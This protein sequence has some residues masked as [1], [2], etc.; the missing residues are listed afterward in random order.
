M[1][2]SRSA[3]AARCLLALSLSALHAACDSETSGE[4]VQ[5]SWQLD[6]NSAGDNADFTTAT[7]YDVHLEQAVIALGA[8]YA[9][10]PTSTSQSAVAQ[11]FRFSSVA[12]AHGGLDA[13][14]GRSV[15]AE[16]PS[17]VAPI[18]IDALSPEVIP[19]PSVMAEAGS[20][21]AV[22]LELAEAGS[23]DAAPLQ[24]A[25][26]FVRGRATNAEHSLHFSATVSEA[27]P[28]NIDLTG[29]QQSL[30]PRSVLHIQVHPSAWFEHCDF[31]QLQPATSEELTVAPADSQ[32]GRAHV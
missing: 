19:L 25:I 15:L 9:Y 16:L 5:V 24:G 11:L 4:L 3:R 17:G 2:G 7:G 10:S 13:E 1:F 23:L 6:Q 21:E 28:R 18:A 30:G 14:A 12:H 29:L 32:I 8:A 20:V 27:S 31:G 22:K 26:A